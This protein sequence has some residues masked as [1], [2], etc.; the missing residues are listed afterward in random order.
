MNNRISGLY[1]ITP[2][3][4]DT[5]KLITQVQLALQGGARWLQYRN[6]SAD[7]SLKLQQ[8][9]AL[10]SVC[11]EFAVPLIVNDSLDMVL[12]TDAAGAHLGIQDCSIPDARIKLGKNKIIGASCYDDLERAL[13]CQAQGADYVAF[14]SF[15][16]SSVKPD[17][18]RASLTLLREAKARLSVPVVAVGGINLQN[19]GLLIDAGADAVG[20]I[21]AV[22]NAPD[23]METAKKFTAL[24][25]S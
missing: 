8:A 7:Q 14:G 1:A 22:F 24:F 13:K 15:Y 23:I 25:A 5:Q 3:L 11:R 21:S 10:M 17:A 19:A 4:D 9:N 16:P 20:V 12:E 2:D 18:A 6:K